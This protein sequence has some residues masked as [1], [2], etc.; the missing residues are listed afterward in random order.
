[1]ETGHICQHS[2]TGA[3][4]VLTHSQRVALVVGKIGH[5]LAPAPW[6]GRRSFARLELSTG[7][8]ALGVSLLLV[9]CAAGT[10]ESF[11]VRP[12]HHRSLNAKQLVAQEMLHEAKAGRFQAPPNGYHYGAP[13]ECRVD[14]AHGFHG[15]PIYLC[16]IAVAKLKDA[17]LY[18]WGAWYRG[19]LHTHNTDPNLIKTVTGPFDPPF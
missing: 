19:A 18:E 11:S 3:S 10:S 1:M 5:V 17:H 8:V 7:L 12:H 15:A 6:N 9:G 2:E 14:S 16:K 13:V 4:G